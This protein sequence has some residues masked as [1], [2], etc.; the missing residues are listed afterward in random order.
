MSDRLSETATS[1]GDGGGVGIVT[2]AKQAYLSGRA[3]YDEATRPHG[4]TVT[5]FGALRRLAMAPGM[6]GADL[7]RSLGVTP[8]A[9]TE[10]AVGL[11]NQ[12]LITREPDKHHGRILRLRLT[13]AG[14]S[15]LQS[16]LPRV[17]AI[18]DRLLATFKSSESQQL[19]ELLQRF[20]D[21]ATAR[22]EEPATAAEGTV[23]DV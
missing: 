11:G 3:V 7:A 18:E 23:D 2:L 4:V 17:E 5:Q 22:L 10:L 12:G 1:G 8:Q 6:S 13:E 15:V 14:C 20:I 21:V 19:R 9:L 16:C